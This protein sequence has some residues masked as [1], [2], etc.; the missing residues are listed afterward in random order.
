MIWK[1]M[2]LG[3]IVVLFGCGGGGAALTGEPEEGDLSFTRLELTPAS[4][5]IAVG[6]TIQ[7]V[8]SPKDELGNTIPGLPRPTFASSNQVT[9]TVDDDGVVTGVSA[10]DVVITASLAAGGVTRTASATVSVTSGERAANTVTTPGLSFDPSSL[11]VVAGDTVTWEFSGAVH[12]VTFVSRAPPG[13]N[14]PDQ[15]TGSAVNRVFPDAGTFAYDCTIHSGMSGEIVVES[16]GS[17][18]FTTLSVSPATP[19]IVLGDTVRLRAT[20]RDQFGNAMTGLPE[21]TFSSSDPSIGSV[22]PTGLVTGAGGGTAVVTASLTHQGITATAQAT[23]SV[24]TAQ[25]GNQTV[26]TPNNSFDPQ[27][28]TIAAGGTVTWQFSEAVHNVTFGSSGPPGGNIPDQDPGNAVSRTFT[29]AGTYGYECTRHNGMTGQVM[30]EP[31]DGPQTFTSLS[32]SP[33]LWAMRRGATKMLTVTPVDQ[34]GV[35]MSGLPDPTFTSGNPE[36]AAIDTA[37]VVTGVAEGSTVI[38]VSLTAD[39]QTR[40]ADVAISVVPPEAAIVIID[41]DVY[42]PDPVEVAP[43]GT[44]IWEVRGSAHNMTFDSAPP[45]GS[46]PATAPGNAVA[47]T[48]PSAGD[49]DYECTLHGEK[50]RVRVR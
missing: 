6:A 47:R 46:I 34:N 32:V 22:D 9:A 21:P 27:S 43:G 24:T 23:V 33:S 17:S 36:V 3:G 8:A 42:E 12:N 39:G 16:P 18:T 29:T 14:I 45:G 37:G 11:V 41:G 44:V 35:A 38:T 15:Q 1:R 28:V 48:F 5:V 13:G 30:V 25:S 10:G 40:T 4:A 49:Y 50:G 2:I 31:N 7:L 19:S 26:T 20:P